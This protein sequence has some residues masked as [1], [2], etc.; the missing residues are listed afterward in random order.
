MPKRQKRKVPIS[1]ALL[2]VVL[3][4]L[5]GSLAGTYS[6]FILGTSSALINGIVLVIAGLFSLLLA[7][8][9]WKGTKWSWCLGI[10]VSTVLALTIFVFNVIGFAIGTIIGCYMVTKN[11]RSYFKMME[12]QSSIEYLITYGWAFIIIAIVIGVLYFY[13]SSSNNVVNNTCNFVNGAYCNDIIIGTNTID[14]TTTVG[15]LLINNQK[16]PIENPEISISLNNKNTTQFSCSP[17]FVLPGGS[18]LCIVMVPINSNVGT[19]LSGDIYLNATDCGL[20]VS[21][22]ATHN[23]NTGVE[24]TYLGV[25]SGHAQPVPSTQSSISLTA[26]NYTQISNGNPDQL[27]AIVMLF[28]NPLKGATVNFTSSNN[29]Y[30]VSPNI[31]TTNAAGS[32]FSYISGKSPGT[33]TVNAIYGGISNSIVINFAK[34][35]ADCSQSSTSTTTTTTSSTTT[36]ISLLLDNIN[37]GNGPI[38]ATYD[39]GNGYVYVINYASGTVS[40]ISGTSVIATIT[41]GSDP[42]YATYDSGNGY[43]YVTNSGSGTVSV[44]SGTSVIAT[45]SGLFDARYATYDLS[46]GYV[47]VTY[48]D[49]GTAS[50]ISGTSVTN[51]IY[52]YNRRQTASVYDPASG[53]VYI[54]TPAANVVSVISDNSVIAT[55]SVGN[56]P[57]SLSY[58]SGN[59]YVYVVNSGDGTASVISGTSVIATIPVSGSLQGASVYNP[60]NGYIYV[61]GPNDG[62][63][64]VISGTSVI[65]T[66]TVGSDPVAAVDDTSGNGYIFVVNSGSGTVYI[67][68]GTSVIG[69]V[70]VESDPV[71]ATYDSGNNYVY[72]MNYASNTVSVLDN[73]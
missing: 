64:S 61:A 52:A 25:F 72:V 9:L 41:V 39:S 70:T 57:V 13:V 24:Q 5:I 22:L 43:V 47:Y 20:A 10:V 53:Y 15:F 26:L 45:I 30:L 60:N 51:T 62:I 65:G 31:T 28:G 23:C 3:A 29:L 59:G 35:I 40:V 21:Y 16:Y 48:S 42:I 18:I 46:N 63:V 32:A 36:T 50:V 67:I 58:D 14:H 2:G 11:T 8:G 6:P 69:I 56:G 73:S 49:S 38:N 1:I 71:A 68:S 55:T 4:A 34:C 33:V 54:V 12:A 37:V 27:T 7:Y 17:D 66:A 19:F 44:I